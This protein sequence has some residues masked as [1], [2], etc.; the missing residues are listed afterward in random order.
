[1]TDEKQ[2]Q[3]QAIDAEIA[4]FDRMKA[5]LEAHH[6]GKWVVIHQG[7]LMGSFDTFNAAATEAQRRFGRGPYL[8]R[9][10]GAPPM[11]LPASVMFRPALVNT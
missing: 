10:V 9:E 6:M 4:A 8:I 11:R 7:A 3:E 1:M 2:R 5:D